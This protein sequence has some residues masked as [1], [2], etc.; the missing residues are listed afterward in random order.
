MFG[1]SGNIN[2][3]TSRSI[4]RMLD[5]CGC[6]GASLAPGRFQRNFRKVIS[7]LIRVI[8]GWS[9]SRKIVVK[10]MHM[11]LTDGKS[12][13]V[14]VMAWCRQATSHYLI[15]CWPWSLSPYGVIRPQWVNVR[16]TFFVSLIW[17]PCVMPPHLFI[18]YNWCT[19]LSIYEFVFFYVYVF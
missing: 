12:T 13:L 19:Y 18:E 15:Q 10:W 9:I 7:Q 16:I 5:T 2:G 4:A 14:Q 3:N 11:E 8:D 17:W 6:A 1:R